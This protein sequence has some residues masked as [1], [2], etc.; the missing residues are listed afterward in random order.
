M[1]RRK[2]LQGVNGAHMHK[3]LHATSK[4]YAGKKLTKFNV[5]KLQAVLCIAASAAVSISLI[6]LGVKSFV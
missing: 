5:N 3:T 6:L 4:Y 1:T 2:F